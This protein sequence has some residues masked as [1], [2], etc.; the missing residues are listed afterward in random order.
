MAVEVKSELRVDQALPI[1]LEIPKKLS[2]QVTEAIRKDILTLT[3]KFG[4]MERTEQAGEGAENQ[5]NQSQE[6]KPQDAAQI[7]WSQYLEIYLTNFELET[8]PVRSQGV[9]IDWDLLLNWTPSPGK[10]LEENLADLAARYQTLW[11]V[12]TEHFGGPQQ[13]ELLARLDMVMMAKLDQLFQADLGKLYDFLVTNG[14]REAAETI[15]P[16]VQRAGFALAHGEI[17]TAAGETR[18]AGETPPRVGQEPVLRGKIRPGPAS[19]E[20]GTGEST[21]KAAR[22]AMGMGKGPL[23]SPA[24]KE[25]RQAREF[26]RQLDPPDYGRAEKD[27]E[28]AAFLRQ[29][30]TAVL[31]L[32]TE[33]FL[34]YADLSPGFAE[35]MGRAMDQ[36]LAWREPAGLSYPAAETREAQTARAQAAGRAPQWERDGRMAARTVSN[37]ADAVRRDAAQVARYMS[38]ALERSGSV[39]Q[40]V[41]EGARYART[42]AQER[43][44]ARRE[45][46]QIFW[47]TLLF[48]SGEATGRKAPMQLIRENW[49]EFIKGMGFQREKAR[50]LYFGAYESGGLQAA[51]TGGE[52]RGAVAA[53][54]LAAFLAP[55]PLIAF[56]AGRPGLAAGLFGLDLCAGLVLARLLGKSNRGR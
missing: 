26:L 47:K 36:F 4:G 56:L 7:A 5:G 13:M 30:D 55:P 46:E 53:G 15:R 21:A 14:Q 24:V 16:S 49:N 32:K 33:V 45:T 9:R 34:K 6:E 18:R 3:S 27:A 29:I 25:L 50:E 38:E 31:T 42:L 35:T 44:E 8:Q 2:P 37:E 40:A 51:G 28:Q 17:L 41:L 39:R 48:G 1:R 19:A 22:P 43:G 11:R 52:L 10:T 54:A 12:I 20:T 23:I